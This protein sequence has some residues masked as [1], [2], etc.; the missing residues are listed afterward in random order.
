MPDRMGA[1]NRFVYILR[2]LAVE[3]K[4][5]FVAFGTRI[6][7]ERYGAEAVEAYQ[8]RLVGLGVTMLGPGVRSALRWGRP[9]LVIF[10]YCFKKTRFIDEV[11]ALF[12]TARVVVDNGDVAYRRMLSKAGHTQNREDQTAAED[13]KRAEL[14]VY[15][16]VDAILAVSEDDLAC[17]RAYIPDIRAYLIPNIHATGTA[18]AAARVC[19]QLIFVGSFLHEPNVDAVVW[20]V[21]E[22][23]PLIWAQRPDVRLQ[24]VGYGPPPEV[25][26]LACARVEVIGYV[27]S[28][29]PWLQAAAISIAP[30]R[31]GAG[32]KGKIGEAMA[33]GLPVV[34]TRV[35]IEGFGL[36]PDSNVLVGDTAELFAQQVLRLLQCDQLRSDIGRAGLQFIEHHFSEAAVRKQ[37]RS[38]MNAVPSLPVKRP[39]PL[40]TW[41]ILM[42]A[43][44]DRNV[45]WRFKT[46]A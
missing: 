24:I 5:A 32:V 41:P 45:R 37:V 34:T 4:I 33:F 12:P 36:T 30:L 44:F 26:A 42:A 39:S 40:K 35:G 6:Q 19:N 15:R 46:S 3:H 11:R 8:Q 14:E 16:S 21:R 17:V 31:F 7:V 38:M 23:L 20:T 25:L 43:W 10:E 9:D 18:T 22:I 29:A 2:L 1:D 27:A 28:T 13:L